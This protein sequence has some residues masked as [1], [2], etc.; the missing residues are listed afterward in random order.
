MFI[1][2]MN[3]VLLVLAIVI[4]HLKIVYLVQLLKQKTQVL[5]NIN[6]LVMGLDLI[7]DQAFH[8]LVVGLVKMY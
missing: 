5:K 3:L 2:F 6:I 8:F 1:L 7:E 4:L